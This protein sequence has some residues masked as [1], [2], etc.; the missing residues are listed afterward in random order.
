M[1][2]PRSAPCRRPL[3]SLF[4]WRP[5][6]LAQASVELTGW[7]FVRATVQG[8]AVVLLAR[9]LGAE[10]YGSFV[11]ALAMAGIA[12]SLAGI[13]IPSVLLRDG[14]RNPLDLPGLLSS[15]LK[16]WCP[17]VLALTAATSAIAA[18]LLPPTSAPIPAI[19][20]VIFAEIVA[21]SL[22][23]LLG[24]AFQ[25]RRQIRTYGVVQAGLPIIRLVAMVTMWVSG[26][27]ELTVW[28]YVY[29]A[30]GLSY[31][32]CIGWYA[33]LRIGHLPGG[34]P[35][36]S[37]IREGI[38]FAAGGVSTRLQ[39]EYNKPLLAQAA[40]ADA[41]HFNVAQRM[42]D[43][44]SLPILALQ[45]VLW[46][47]L[48]GNAKDR[49]TL[50]IAGGTLICM[51]LVAAGLLVAVAAVVPM[52][53]GEEFGSAAE[54][55]PWLALLPLLAVL[56]AIGNFRL[57]TTQRAH[58]LTRIYLAGGLAGIGFSSLLI[59]TYGLVG[60]AGAYYATEMVGLLTIFACLRITEP[61]H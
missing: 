56:R 61:K 37:L 25:A 11:A 16:A 51:S 12:A 58:L 27:G 29:A 32:A 39:A 54:L 49:R 46:P 44:I 36:G 8:A 14:S 3:L 48:Y 28:L 20:G 59:P 41:G 33:H 47:R 52:I 17:S 55:L 43:L 53:L 30:S 21:V 60:A 10:D 13:G 45:E 26:Q 18:F 22:V 15:A 34:P 31:T 57:I 2:D 42:V 24:R 4:T 35:P 38:P 6:Q 9:I 50:L 23:E 19:L 40:Y 5:G 7:L 1:A